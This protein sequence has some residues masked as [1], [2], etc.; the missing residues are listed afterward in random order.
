M[1]EANAKAAALMALINNQSTYQITKEM[2]STG[3]FPWNETVESI[4][5]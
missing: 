5:S 4:L 3:A 1:Q 2:F